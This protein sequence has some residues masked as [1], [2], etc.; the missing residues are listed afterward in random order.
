MSS[1]ALPAAI[2]SAAADTT[3]YLKELFKR[4]GAGRRGMVCM[5]F[6]RAEQNM[7]HRIAKIRVGFV[8]SLPLKPPFS[9]YLHRICFLRLFLLFLIGFYIMPSEVTIP[10]FDIYIL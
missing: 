3:P 5:E 10:P 7:P 2:L 8:C 9:A 6:G 4:I 1:N